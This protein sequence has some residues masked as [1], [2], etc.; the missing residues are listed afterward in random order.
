MSGQNYSSVECLFILLI[1]STLAGFSG[2]E[3]NTFPHLIDAKDVEKV[4]ELDL[5]KLINENVYSKIF[6]RKREEHKLL[7]KHLQSIEDYGKRYKL[8][9]LGIDE[10]IRII[11]EEGGKLRGNKITAESEFPKVQELMNALSQFLENTC[12]FGEMVLHFPD[13]SYR[14]VKGVSDW[15]T[16]MTEALNYTKTFVKIL[17]EKSIELLGL[18]NQEIN[19]DQRTPEYVNPYREGLQ[20]SESVKSKKKSK[21]KSKKGPALSPS[22]TEL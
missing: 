16:L 9:K 6:V 13:M 7:V 17:D 4:P 5:G 22:K 11:R 12:L 14:I 21:S 8:M 18:L 2:M 3:K 1:T 15:R 20:A 19:E 10:I